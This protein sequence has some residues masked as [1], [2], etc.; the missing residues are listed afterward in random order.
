MGKTTKFQLP[1]PEDSDVANV[2]L[3]MKKLAEKTEEILGEHEEDIEKAN[4]IIPTTGTTG[5][6]LKKKSDGSTE[7]A[8]ETTEV[9]NSK[10]IADKTKKTYSAE[11]IDGLVSDDG[12]VMG[13]EYTTYCILSQVSFYDSLR[14]FIPLKNAHKYNATITGFSGCKGSTYTNILNTNDPSAQTVKC[15]NGILVSNTNL[16]FAGCQCEIKF[17]LSKL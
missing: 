8:D 4:N 2:P 9:V 10:T 17:K 15:I 3:D 1:Y 6:V 12:Y 16:S 5:Q 11:I 13:E 7:W 14:A